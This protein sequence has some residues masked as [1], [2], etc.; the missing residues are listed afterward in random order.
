MGARGNGSKDNYLVFQRA[1][2]MGARKLVL[3]KGEYYI[4]KPLVIYTPD[5]EIAGQGAGETV[6]FGD[7]NLLFDINTKPLLSWEYDGKINPRA[8]S[9]SDAHQDVDTKDLLLHISSPHGMP[10][11]T[12]GGYTSHHTALITNQQAGQ[13]FLD[14][15][16]EIPFKH[17]ITVSI[18]RPSG[19]VLR[20]VTL[21]T[22]N[23]PYMVQVRNRQHVRFENVVFRTT[24]H[25]YMGEYRSADPK[26]GVSAIAAYGCMD[27]IVDSC[28]F[29]H[30]WYG[31]MAH[32][33]CYNVQLR[34]STAIESRHINNNGIGTDLFRVENC[35]TERCE[36]GFD[37]HPTALG[38]T[39]INCR[40]LESNAR[41]TFRGRRDSIVNCIF[42]HGI[43]L[44][45]DE[46]IL[47]LT[48]D[49]KQIYKYLTGTQVSGGNVSIFA[50]NV[51]VVNCIFASPVLPAL[52]SGSFSMDSVMIDLRNIKTVETSAITIADSPAEGHTY[53]FSLKNITVLGPSQPLDSP[54]K[55]GVYIPMR[56]G[57]SGDFENIF[58][59]GFEKG[60]VL[61]GGEE[62]QERYKG[63]GMKNVQ[64]RNCAY[65]VFQQ[66]FFDK[67]LR[68]ADI[69]VSDCLVNDNAPGRIKQL[70]RDGN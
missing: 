47:N 51:K 62:S 36:G 63:I 38:T 67:T 30:I 64:I 40:D 42:D 45:T 1:L 24:R 22:D 50:S 69:R 44:S 70:A 60:L 17:D 48:H 25:R 27:I 15:K 56:R 46:G 53:I 14:R 39:F 4:S 13:L 5:V 20:D 32:E 49:T 41:S 29:E 33:G 68:V 37:S 58:I 66:D 26:L 9:I 35:I 31:L 11:K 23:T 59:N 3:N 10:E 54:L 7:G 16:I 19:F 34:N 6:I 61:Y 43:E 12:S 21:E 65:G 55:I 57:V 8:N 18:Y 28:R 2:D 52:I